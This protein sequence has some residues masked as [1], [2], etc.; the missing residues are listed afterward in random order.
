M[1]R[2][3]NKV[4]R[5]DTIIETSLHIELDSYDQSDYLYKLKINPESENNYINCKVKNMLLTDNNNKLFIVYDY[6]DEYIYLNSFSDDYGTLKFL[7]NENDRLVA[8][9]GRLN[10][11]FKNITVTDGELNE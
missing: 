11:S 5:I 6:D 8:K 4:Y 9:I 7:Q 3:L 1:E 2:I 10:D